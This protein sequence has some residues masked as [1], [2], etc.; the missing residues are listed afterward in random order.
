MEKE[1]K[2]NTTIDVYLKTQVN[3]VWWMIFKDFIFA[4]HYS[5]KN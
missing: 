5:Y 2:V 3:A 1:P 4:E